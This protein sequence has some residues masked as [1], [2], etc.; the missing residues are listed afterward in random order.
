MGALTTTINLPPFDKSSWGPG[1]WQDEPDTKVWEGPHGLKCVILRNSL[2]NLCGYVELPEGHPWRDGRDYAPADVH[3]GVT[4]NGTFGDDLGLPGH[5]VGFDCA[6]HMDMVPSMC[7]PYGKYRDTMFVAS[8]CGS[9]ACQVAKAE[10]A[11]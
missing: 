7:R 3:G 8:H 5:F 10:E 2:G 6:H 1:P 11:N 9:L 4:F